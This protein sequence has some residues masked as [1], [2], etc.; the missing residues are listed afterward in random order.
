MKRQISQK[1][2]K[3]IRDLVQ[4]IYEKNNDPFHNFNHA[5]TTSKLATYIAEK[6]GGNTEVCLVAGLLHDIAPKT[7]GKPH[8]EQSAKMACG[9]LK[10]MKMPED[11][12]KQVAAA[13]ANHDSSRRH[14]IDTM[15]GKIVYDADKLH[16]I[17]PV[18]LLREYGDLIITGEDLNK[19][20]DMALGYLKNLN[21]HITTKTGKKIKKELRKFNVYFIKLYN[22]YHKP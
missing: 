19:V 7:R 15:E 5:I 17:G 18:G 4:S 10:K 8:G 3:K 9:L 11:F 13:I 20:V 6:E 21:P 12:I 2:I 16:C 22:K 1:Q 14:L